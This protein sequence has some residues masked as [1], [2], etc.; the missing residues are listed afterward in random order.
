MARIRTQHT[1][2][3]YISDMTEG[4]L[5]CR[6]R[7]RHDW[8][9]DRL[10]PN[11]ALPKGITPVRQHDGSYQIAEWCRDCEKERTW[12]TLPKGIYDTDVT[13]RYKNPQRWVT[14]PRDVEY[15]QRDLKAA[16]L[17]IVADDLFGAA[18]ETA[19]N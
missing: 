11:R 12:T 3:R 8:P 16:K 7:G 6:A 10:R 13:Y 1:L 18:S 17:A 19:G 5:T 2:N 9:S 15:T 4:E 14:I